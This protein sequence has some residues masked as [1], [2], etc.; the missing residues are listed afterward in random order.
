MRCTLKDGN[1]PYGGTGGSG[2][3]SGSTGTGNFTAG[4]LFSLSNAGDVEAILS[5]LS[6]SGENQADGADGSFMVELSASDIGLPAG[7]SVTLTITGNGVDYRRDAAASADGRIL[8]EVPRIAAGTLI[9]VTLEL[10]EADGSIAATGTKIQTVPEGGCDFRIAMVDTAPAPAPTPAPTPAPAPMPE[11]FVLMGDLYVCIHEVTQSEYEA[12]CGYGGSSSPSPTYGMG[13]DYPAYYVSWYD[14][15]VYCNLRSMA[16]NLTPYYKI[17]GSTNPAEW[18]GVESTGGKYR[19]SGG[20]ISSAWNAA[21]RV[22]S[23]DGYRLPTGAEWEYAA[24]GG[25]ANDSYT[26][27][28]SN[29]IDAVAW[30]SSNSGDGG[31]ST[32]KKSHPVKTKEPNSAGIYDMSGNVREWCWDASSS[33]RD[34]CGGSWDSG[35]EV[36]AVSTRY[37]N[38]PYN[39]SSRIGFRVVRTAP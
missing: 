19:V 8:F 39:R 15:L 7:G 34:Y 10:K 26:Y 22:S 29:D 4:D 6:G 12:Y 36:C 38:Y 32:N 1:A 2:S 9:T 3:G 28:G 30:Y 37:S 5:I 25:P 21:E 13:P 35:A 14:A 16:E 33:N 23:A 27:S 17:G 24:K 31:G 20:S 18:S 11:G